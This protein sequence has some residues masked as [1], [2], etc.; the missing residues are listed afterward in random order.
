MKQLSPLDAAF[1]GLDNSTM[2]GNISSILILDPADV[3][4]PFDLEYLLGFLGPRIEGIR[5]FRQRLAQVPFGLDRPYWVDDDRFEL[6]YHVRESALPKPG[7]TSQLLEL[8]GRLHERP[9]DMNRPLWETYL[10]TGLEGGRV[11]LITKTHHVVIDGVSGMEMLGA[12]VDLEPGPVPTAASD[13]ETRTPP[14]GAHLLARSAVSL[15]HRPAQA[16]TVLSGLAKWAPGALP[17]PS[18]KPRNPFQPSRSA[19]PVGG[20]ALPV[21]P[22]VSSFNAK[23]SRRRRVG[24]SRLPLQDIR[25]VKTVFDTSVNDVVMAVTAGA[26]RRWLLHDGGVLS[27]PLVAMVPVAVKGSDRSDQGNFVTAMF[28]TLPTHLEDPVERLKRSSGFTRSA[29][30]KKGAVPPDV[31][32]S[33][34]GFA[35]P[36]IFGRAARAVWETGLFRAIRPFNLVVSNVP[37]GAGQAYVAGARLEEMYPISVLTDGLG[38]NVT[39]LGYKGNLHVGITTDPEL[40]PNPQEIADWMVEELQILLDAAAEQG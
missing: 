3:E 27:S 6:R 14:S 2:T 39:L 40:V 23:I 1:L 29:K 37:G 4:D 13:Y 21:R 11:A 26:V 20:E 33:A 10:V 28:T 36:V 16:W 34:L 17:V 7:G 35:P 12:L 25:T 8:A 19:A 9:L 5:A 31:L 22:P 38:L 18:L 30:K 32:T 15:L 24:V